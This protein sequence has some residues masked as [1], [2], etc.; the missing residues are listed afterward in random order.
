MMPA[1]LLSP[2]SE[3]LNWCPILDRYSHQAW[4]SK[5]WCGSLYLWNPSSQSTWIGSTCNRKPLCLTYS[6]S[7]FQRLIHV[8]YLHHHFLWH[9]WHKLLSVCWHPQLPIPTRVPPSPILTILQTSRVMC[10]YLRHWGWY[11]LPLYPFWLQVST[12]QVLTPQ[13]PAA[14]ALMP[15]TPT[16]QA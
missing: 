14:Q 8:L 3:L 4:I 6:P 9:H 15:Q 13:M 12:N 2:T 11:R 10:L 5:P 1:S 7:F 16:A